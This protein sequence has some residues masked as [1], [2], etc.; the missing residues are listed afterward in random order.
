[1][2]LTG[3]ALV[4]LAMQLVLMPTTL[5]QAVASSSTA[6]LAEEM[7]RAVSSFAQRLSEGLGLDARS[8]VFSTRAGEVQGTWLLNQGI[9]MELSTPL[10]AARNTITLQSVNSSLQQLSGQ[11]AGLVE[12]QGSALVQRSDLEALRESMA[13]SLWRDKAGAHY[14]VLL[15]HISSLEVFQQID[16]ALRSAA[17]SARLLSSSGVLDNDEL[18]QTRTELAQLRT[19]LGERLQELAALQAEVRQAGRDSATADPLREQ[20]QHRL[21]ALLAAMEPIRAAATARASELQRKVEE[22]RQLQAL[23]WQQ[24]LDDFEA[25]LFTLVCND[26]DVSAV[27]P[28]DHYLTLV[29]PGLGDAKESGVRGSRIL[30]LRKSDMLSCHSGI[31]SAARLGELADGYSF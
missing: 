1:M 19:A 6:Q 10:G 27:L 2:R 29:L 26:S 14:R 13:L 20:W 11:L 21:N 8:G 16:T 7:Q 17:E 25:R 12:T 31:V 3:S 15:S 23:Q 18:A 4:L 22:N 24:E 9:V 28:D 5:A 30:V